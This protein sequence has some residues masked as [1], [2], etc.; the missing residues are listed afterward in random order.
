MNF[1]KQ[2]ILR[3][4][5][6]RD[7][8]DE[9]REH[10]EERTADLVAQGMSPATA[11][12]AARREFGNVALT[13]EQ[14]REVWH[15]AP[16]EEILADLRYALRQLRRAPAFAAAATATLA[17]GIGANTAVFSVVNA[18]VLRPLPFPDSGRLV[19][20]QARR[21]QAGTPSE[22]NL[23]YPQ[24]FEFRKHTAAIEHLVSYHDTS[25]A[26]SGAGDAVNVPSEI[27]SW[28]LF[29]ALRVQ[30][31]AGR[32]FQ[33]DD[34]AAAVHTVILGYRLWQGKFNADPAVVGRTVS[35]NREPY[36]VI[37]VA[38]RDFV[39]PLGNPDR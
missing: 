27:V 3:R 14:S 21:I 31:L 1:L 7:V 16:L 15:Y 4:K 11:L 5:T 2:L 38:P 37:G 10:I 39:F 26:L 30:P 25:M 28:D 23:S 32:T 20:V 35:L 29:D 18:V 19:S 24:F 9:I 8:D 17:L 33:P 13:A 22:E 12:L 6:G 36:T 34:E